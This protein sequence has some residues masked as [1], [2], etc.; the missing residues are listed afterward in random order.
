MIL[1][2]SNILKQIFHVRNIMLFSIQILIYYM[3]NFSRKVYHNY[4]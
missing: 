4:H 2:G 1:G 3:L